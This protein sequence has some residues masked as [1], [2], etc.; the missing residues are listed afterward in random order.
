MATPKRD[1]VRPLD[2]KTGHIDM[3]HGAGGRLTAQLI[4]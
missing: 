2:L 3:N 4:D 1:Y